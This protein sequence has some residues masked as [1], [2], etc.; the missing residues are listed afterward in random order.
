MKKKK[1]CVYYDVHKAKKSLI[2][3][4]SYCFQRGRESRVFRT[5]GIKK[6]K[7]KKQNSENRGDSFAAVY[8]EGR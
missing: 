4:L 5:N 7:K 2:P 8:D 3:L 1:N 6:K